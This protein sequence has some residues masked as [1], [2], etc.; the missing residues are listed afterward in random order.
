[1]WLLVFTVGTA[2]LVVVI[3]RGSWTRLVHLPLQGS[4]LFVAGVL[5]QAALEI[6]DFAPSRIE[7]TGYGLLMLSYVFLL[8]FCLVNVPLR[9]WPSSPWASC[10]TLW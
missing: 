7:T 8:A 5:L 9:A 2:A 10:S 1:M 6:V 3:A 4:L